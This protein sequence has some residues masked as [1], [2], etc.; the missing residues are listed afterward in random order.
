MGRGG[1]QSNADNILYGVAGRRG[2]GDDLSAVEV[3]EL[4]VSAQAEEAAREDTYSADCPA[5]SGTYT[6]VH[7]LQENS[8][9]TLDPENQVPGV[10]VIGVFTSAEDAEDAAEECRRKRLEKP[11]ESY[12]YD[13]DIRRRPAYSGKETSPMRELYEHRYS[14]F[15]KSAGTHC[16]QKP[17]HELNDQELTGYHLEMGLPERE[18]GKWIKV[19]SV[20]SFLAN[21]VFQRLMKEHGFEVE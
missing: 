1:T 6:Y 3:M 10:S 15:Y 12:S 8:Y 16:V 21:E 9:D 11:D 5:R 19:T 7:V 13:W 2:E 14:G 20:N 18:N 17:E 4:S